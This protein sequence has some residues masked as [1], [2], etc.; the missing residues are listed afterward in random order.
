M[1][2]EIVDRF[3]GGIGV[4]IGRKQCALGI[5]PK[6]QHRLAGI[7]SQ[8]PVTIFVVFLK[9]AFDSAAASDDVTRTCPGK[10]RRWRPAPAPSYH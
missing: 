6:I 1:K 8:H 9:I 3:D 2:M 7:C 4:R 5:G 10:I